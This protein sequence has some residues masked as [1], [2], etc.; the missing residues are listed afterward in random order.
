MANLPYAV[1]TPNYYQ[2]LLSS[3]NQVKELSQVPE[4]HLSFTAAI[5]D[6]GAHDIPV[7][8]GSSAD[9]N[10]NSDSFKSILDMD[11]NTTKGIPTT[12][13]LLKLSKIT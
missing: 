6:V 13:Y 9:W 7:F 1:P 12:V 11:S 10:H 3:E 5:S 8:L 4:I 2:V